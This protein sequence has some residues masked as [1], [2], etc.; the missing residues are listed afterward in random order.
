VFNVASGT[1]PFVA[2]GVWIAYPNSATAIDSVANQ[3]T[4]STSPVVA[5]DVSIVPGGFVIAFGGLDSA[6]QTL[7]GTWSGSDAVTENFDQQVEA[8]ATI[9][10]YS[11]A[12][13]Q[14]STTFD[15][16]LGSTGT[17]SKRV[18][19]ASWGAS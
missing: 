13:T 11:I 14:T 4:S 16:S 7:T 18:V 2:I 12:T 6:L 5:S 3:I 15:F 19:A 17:T 1:I 8:T 9:G 10:G